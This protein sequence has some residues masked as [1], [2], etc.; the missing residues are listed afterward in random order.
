LEENLESVSQREARL[1]AACRELE[2]QNDELEQRD[3]ESNATIE[4]LQERIDKMT[5]QYVLAQGELE[6]LKSSSDEVIERLKDEV[7]GTCHWRSISC[8][9]ANWPTNSPMSM[10]HSANHDGIDGKQS[11]RPRSTSK[12]LKSTH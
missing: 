8:S 9:S 5:E 4:Y 11:K 6:D 7:R 10:C 1:K 2:Q 12:L 3:R